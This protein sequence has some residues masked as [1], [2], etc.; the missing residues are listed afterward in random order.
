M[1]FLSPSKKRK[2]LSTYE[3]SQLVE[4]DGDDSDQDPDYIEEKDCSSSSDEEDAEG[5]QNLVTEANKW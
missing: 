3:I 4:N 2:V 5:G 1:V